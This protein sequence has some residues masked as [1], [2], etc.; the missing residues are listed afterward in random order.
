MITKSI[1]DEIIFSDAPDFRPNLTPS[2]IFQLGAFGGGYY[3]EIYSNVTKKKYSKE[4]KEFPDSWWK[5][6]DKSIYLESPIY[7]K[8]INR[9]GVDCG[10]KLNKYD[11]FG[12]K[13]W[14][15]KDWIEPQDPYGWVQWYCRFYRGRRSPDD[16]RQISRWKAL[17]GETGRFRNRLI[18]MCYKANTS[19]D[20]ENISPVIRQVLLQWGY[21]LTRA[22]YKKFVKSKYF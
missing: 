16:A 18:G 1:D 20:D 22:D 13:F 14:E 11:K 7:D 4:W 5:G 9:Y 8:T 3:R 12:L 6:L 2:E 19:F 17:A 15:S 10:A 21:Q